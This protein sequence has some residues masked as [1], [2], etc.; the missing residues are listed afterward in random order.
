[1]E[2]P[3]YTIL[4]ETL[5]NFKANGIASELLDAEQLKK[6]YN[7]NFPVNVKGIL[8]RTAGVLLANKCLR[9]IQVKKY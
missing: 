6:K 1:M 3:P 8:E 5:A 4:K 2:E 7:F 9:A